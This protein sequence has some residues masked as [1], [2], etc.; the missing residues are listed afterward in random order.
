MCRVDRLLLCRYL[1][2]REWK[3]S[4]FWNMKNNFVIHMYTYDSFLYFIRHRN[5][6][7]LKKIIDF[8]PFYMKTVL[9]LLL[10]LWFL[11]TPQ[12][13]YRYDFLIFFQFL[14]QVM[15]IFVIRLQTSCNFIIFMIFNKNKFF[16]P[17]RGFEE[18]WFTI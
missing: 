5:L 17:W 16:S 1:L 7:V 3:K 4:Y 13:N 14:G 9:S 11:V 18:I 15:Y 10:W 2:P 8:F 6:F 12:F